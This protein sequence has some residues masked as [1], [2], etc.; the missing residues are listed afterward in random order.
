MPKLSRRQEEMLFRA[1][2]EYIHGGE[3]VSSEDIRKRYKLNYS[4]A[5][6]RNELRDLAELGYLAQPHTSAG[7]VPTD[8]GYRWYVQELERNYAAG[9]P[10]EVTRL[11]ESLN[12]PS[13]FYRHSTELLAP[14]VQALVIGGAVEDETESF[15]MSGFRELMQTPE[16]EDGELR[17][18]FGELVDSADTLLRKIARAHEFTRPQ[19]FIGKENPLPAGRQ[20]SMIIQT[21]D[22]EDGRGVIAILGSKRMH[23][24]RG[25]KFLE[26]IRQ[27]LEAHDHHARR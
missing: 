10:G 13:D 22:L 27:L 21:L 20:C 23:Y 19:V 17:E 6:I 24:D 26:G 8:A 1:V 3:P 11:E 15:F 9:Q 2:G 7:R 16:F 18:A 25:I 12:E 5:T 4:P 14:L